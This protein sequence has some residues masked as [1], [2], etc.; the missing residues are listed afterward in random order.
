MNSK[1]S[2]ECDVCRHA[3]EHKPGWFMPGQAEK[4][5]E[6][7]NMSVEELFKTKL[8]VDWWEQDEDHPEDIFLLSPGIVGEEPGSEF[9]SD[10]RGTCVFYKE[11]KCSIHPV[12]PF[13][14]A[15]SIHGE[16][17]E[18]R[19]NDIALAWQPHQEQIK[20]LLGREPQSEYFEPEF[21]GLGMFS[22]LL[23]GY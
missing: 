8:M 18:Y 6:Y 23:R 11:G 14:C 9:P 21:M 22:S 10:P 20:K 19:H 2:C 13:E 1:E 16:R 3:C 17:G 15:D 4:V 7:L 5:A 12:K